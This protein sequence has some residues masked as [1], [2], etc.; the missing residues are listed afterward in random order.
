[1]RFGAVLKNKKIL[2]YGF[3][4]EKIPRCGSVQQLWY[5]L[6]CVSV[7]FSET[8]N[9]TVHFGAVFRYRKCSCGSVLWYIVRCGSARFPVERFFYGAAPLPVGK[10]HNT[11]FS[12]WYTV[13]I[14]RTK[15][16][17]SYGFRAFSR[18][19]RT[20]PLFFFYC[21]STM[22]GMNKSYKPAGRCVRFSGVLLFLGKISNKSDRKEAQ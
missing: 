19:A 12:L 21:F 17:V 15:T 5:I 20:K 22:H 8:R 9:P 16:S 11:V 10:T 7:R 14:N 18:E 2:R 4:K 13:R 1:M 3:E 6:R